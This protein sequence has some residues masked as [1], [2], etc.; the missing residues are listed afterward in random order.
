MVLVMTLSDGPRV[1]A[2]TL[3]RLHAFVREHVR[4][5]SKEGM[6]FEGRVVSAEAFVSALLATYA[7]LP[8]EVQ[9]KLMASALKE[10]EEEC[11][12]TFTDKETA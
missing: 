11:R 2:R 10:L 9:K 3:P 7:S 1:N 8:F 4:R 5:L 12:E 6:Y